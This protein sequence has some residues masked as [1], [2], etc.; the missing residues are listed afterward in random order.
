[1]YDEGTFTEPLV[2]PD[3]HW[4]WVPGEQLKLYECTPEITGTQ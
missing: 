1:M 3:L 2:M 4:E